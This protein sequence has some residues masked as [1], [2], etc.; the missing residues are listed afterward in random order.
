M[1]KLL[2]TLIPFIKELFFDHKDEAN[3]MSARFNTKKWLMFASFIGMLI[4]TFL[5]TQRLL[6]LSLEIVELQD[7]HDT[8]IQKHTALEKSLVAH[9]REIELLKADNAK[10]LK[11]CGEEYPINH[12]TN[13]LKN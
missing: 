7:K 13:R 5:E 9:E 8:L 11:R 6:T 12:R 2:S 10:C 1:L 3:F 4:L